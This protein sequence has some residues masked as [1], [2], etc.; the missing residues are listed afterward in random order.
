MRWVYKKQNGKWNSQRGSILAV[1]TI[2][3]VALLLAVGLAVD[4][5][6]L[7]L[8]GTELQNAADASALAGASALNSDASGIKSAVDRAVEKMNKYEFNG[9]DVAIGRTDVRFAVDL[10]EFDPE[11]SGGKTED[12]PG[13]DPPK[14]RFVQVK[15]P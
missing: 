10:S 12:D 15:I 11:G 2:G 5:S 7:Y 3:M 9:I 4:I 13:I 8:V 14:V 6:H 1:S